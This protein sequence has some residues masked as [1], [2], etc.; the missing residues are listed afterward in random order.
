MYKKYLI[1][2]I[3]PK[4]DHMQIHAVYKNK[5]YNEIRLQMLHS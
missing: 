2:E 1:S 4:Y 5:A 3:K